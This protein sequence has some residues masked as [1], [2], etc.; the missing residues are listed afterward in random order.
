MVAIFTG[1]GV[2]F[3]RGSGS[4]LG[5]AGLLGSSSLGRGSDQVFLNAATGNLVIRQ[6]DEFLV[7]RGP[8]AAV[9]RTYNS[10]GDLSDDNGDNWR[11]STDRRVYGLS[12]T[13]NTPGSTVRRVSGDGSDILYGW[14]AAKAAYVATDGAGA[15]D[16]LTSASGVWTWTDGDSRLRE[17]YTAY[18]TGYGTIWRISQQTDDD[19]NALTFTYTGANLTRLATAD[20]GY[21]DYVWSGDKISQIVTGYTDLQTGAAATLTRTRYGYDASN[22]LTT[23]TVDLSPNDGSVADGKVYVTTYAYD[24][25]SKRVQSIAQSDGSLLSITYGSYGLVE[26]LTETIAAGTTSTTTIAYGPDYTEVTDGL[27]RTTRFD[28]A[29]GNVASPLA[30]WGSINVAKEAATINGAAATKYT[31]QSASS[32]AAFFQSSWVEANR[33]LAFGLT[34]Q[35][36]GSVTSQSLGLYS[37]QTGW[38]PASESSARI[39]SGPG[40]LQQLEGGQWVVT[41]LSTTEGTRVEIS[42]TYR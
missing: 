12:G 34:L 13:L 11:Q 4:V 7:G 23:V 38:G 36:V 32:Y 33:T 31:V 20:G 42:R 21:I 3:E 5:S 14:D 1:A 15:H 19:G 6:Q 25:T 24:G 8:D 18:T 30:V 37:D 40:Q 39:V 28:F 2:G 26:T 16:T 10:L 29:S 22:R 9:S 41:G 27:G 35:G 17:T